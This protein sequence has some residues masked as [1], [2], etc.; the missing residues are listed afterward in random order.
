MFLEPSGFTG[1]QYN[2]RERGSNGLTLDPTGRLT[3]CQH[4]DRRIAR[5]AAD[6]KNFETVV[7]KID[8]RR[9]SSPNDLCFDRAGNLFLR[10]RPTAC[11]PTRSRRP[12]STACTASA[13]MAKSRC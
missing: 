1:A 7:A 6:G 13:P 10:T 11:P 2:G 8:G 9:F 5:L 4:G 3:L 12:P